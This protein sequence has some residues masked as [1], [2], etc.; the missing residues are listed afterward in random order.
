MDRSAYHLAIARERRITPDVCFR[1][2][3]SHPRDSEPMFCAHTFSRKVASIPCYLCRVVA[4]PLGSPEFDEG[5][6]T[7]SRRPGLAHVR[8]F[9]ILFDYLLPG[10]PLF[11][12][13]FWLQLELI[14]RPAV[15]LQVENKLVSDRSRHH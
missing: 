15:G 7:M 13:L 8:C 11:W 2:K 1:W 14:F 10:D 5:R 9:A 12:L 3:P 6:G 4:A